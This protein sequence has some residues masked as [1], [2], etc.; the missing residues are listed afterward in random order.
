MKKIDPILIRLREFLGIRKDTELCEIWG[1]KYGTLNTWKARDAIPKKKLENFAKEHNLSLDWIMNG[2]KAQEKFKDT[3]SFPYFPNIRASAG[4]GYVNED[5]AGY[6]SYPLSYANEILK[7]AN[8]KSIEMILVD[9]VSMSPTLQ[10]EDVIFVDR[11]DIDVKSHKIYVYLFEDEV[12]VKRF[13]KR[14]DGTVEIKSDNVEYGSEIIDKDSLKSMNIIG[15]V[16]KNMRLED[17]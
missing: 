1:L 12:Y 8:L 6:I 17:L 2:S 11:S 13:I 5:D 15:R 4:A 14:L 16:V 7:V 3:I 9:G 10:N